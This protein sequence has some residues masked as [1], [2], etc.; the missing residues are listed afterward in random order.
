MLHLSIFDPAMYELL[1]KIFK[2]VIIKNGF[3]L[4]G[5]TS[6]ALQIGH[7]NSIDFDIFSPDQFDVKELEIILSTSNHYI[8]NY[9]GNNSRMLFGSINGIKCDFVNEPA[10]LLEP[11]IDSAGVNY[12]SIKDIAAMKLHTICGRGKKKDFFDIHALLQL[13]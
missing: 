3:A 7:R 5:G 12:Y 10:T 2:T 8:F 6:L 4:A 13:Y 11:F 9:T 1:Q